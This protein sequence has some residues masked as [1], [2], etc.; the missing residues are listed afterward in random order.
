MRTPNAIHAK[1]PLTEVNHSFRRAFS[2]NRICLITEEF[3]GIN[4]SGGIGACARGLALHLVSLGHIVDV[5]ITDLYMS[6]LVQKDDAVSAL[7]VYRLKDIAAADEAA[8][9]PVDEITKSH[10]VY[11]FLKRMN[12]EVVHFNDWLGSAAYFPF[13]ATVSAMRTHS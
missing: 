4:K 11:R 10:C 5:V 6:Q 1:K 2:M 3:A 9:A 13:S 12:Y 7:Q 8:D